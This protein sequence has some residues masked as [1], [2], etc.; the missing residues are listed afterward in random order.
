MDSIGERDIRL[1][2]G[3]T[4][5][6]SDL[7][8]DVASG[9]GRS[10]GLYYRD[11]RHLSLWQ[12]RLNGRQLHALTAMNTEY[13]EAYFYL[14]E[15]SA[16]APAAPVASLVRR[17]RLSRGLHEQLTVNNRSGQDLPVVLTV[18]FG[19][20]FADLFHTKH[21]L[22]ANGPTFRRV[23]ADEVVLGY[24]RD[25][26]RRYTRIRAPGAFLT[27]ESAT[28]QAT[29]PPGS[30]WTVDL[31]VAVA[32]ETVL[33]RPVPR[34]E[35]N[36]DQNLDEWLASTPRLET[37]WV[38]VADTYHR[39]LV[40]LAGLRYYPDKA[41]RSS[42]PAAGLPWYMA[43]F[44]RDSLITC[45][46]ALPFVPE[47]ARSTLRA[48]AAWQADRMDDFRDAEPG[49]ILHELREG[50][51]A[52]FREWP[53]SP[54][55]GS[56]DSTPLFLILLDEYEAWTGDTGLVHELEGAA[57]AALSWL[58][59]YGDLDGDGYVE[60]RTRTWSHG[61]QNQCWKDSPNSV[62]YPDGRLAPLPR[63]TCELQ[64]YAYDARRRT[65][66]LAREIWRDDALADRL[67][68]A[69]AELKD[70]FNRD[71]W[72]A[73]RGHYAFALDGEKHPVPTLTSNIGHLL[74]SGIVADERVEPVVAHL[75]GEAL[76]S[77]W[78]VRTMS[79]AEPAYNPLAYHR[80]TVWAHDNSL[81]AMGLAGYGHR[82]EATR[83]A[84]SIL[85]AA[86]HFNHRLPECFSGEDRRVAPTPVPYPDA[87]SPQA[88]ATGAPLLMLRVLLGLR[89]GD[90]DPVVD[91][92]LP[93]GVGR[94]ELHG[95]ARRRQGAVRHR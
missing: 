56:A 6:V 14:V 95:L 64:G 2:D 74:W 24:E 33:H 50:E 22:P 45:Y 82:P 71:F 49:K 1:L 83:L 4:F 63:A 28:F 76:F 43:L 10:E 29:V 25:D 23:E 21:R 12:A 77:G 54:Y 32:T 19:A 13:D 84:V 46:Q 92:A 47:L 88:W 36:M 90:P 78:G 37:D 34:R 58:E 7:D 17:R 30:S 65:A 62:V 38:Q 27:T 69:A 18:A 93:A 9:P 57:R 75:L 15:E 41:P 86:V 61:L 67:D 40:D 51:L 94:L 48:L 80:G 52:Y 91:P 66:R 5:L 70:R 68:R 20:D 31:E 59:Q 89:P 79:S 44:G 8:G 81:I 35:P 85:D 16:A 11:T 60:Y 72:L 42:V 73:D 87:A 39:S 26:F 53:Q 55:Y 3:S